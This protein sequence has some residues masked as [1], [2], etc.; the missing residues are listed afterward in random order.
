MNKV[1]CLLKENIYA[2]ITEKLNMYCKVKYAFW[3][4]ISADNFS[5]WQCTAQN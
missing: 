2:Y 5:T 1:S 3:E 4:K